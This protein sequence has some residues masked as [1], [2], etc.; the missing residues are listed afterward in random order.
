MKRKI[1][2]ITTKWPFPV[3][4]GSRVATCALIKV[5]VEAGECVDLL[6][7]AGE[8]EAVEASE[9]AREIG[10]RNCYVLRRPAAT[11]KPLHLIKRLLSAPFVPI[12]F[13][14]YRSRHM[15]ESYRRFFGGD[16][17]SCSERAEAESGALK[18]DVLVYDGPHAAAPSIVRSRYRR[19]A[20]DAALIYRAQNCESD[21][22]RGKAL[23]HRNP[24]TRLFLRFQADR[25]RKFEENLLEAVG[26]VAAV[27]SEDA[28]TFQ[29]MAPGVR[30]LVVPVGRRFQRV[31]EAFNPAE[32]L[33]LLFLGR[34]DWLPNRQGLE[35]LL[36]HVWPEVALRRPDIRLHIAGS[37]GS[38]WLLRFG[39][40]PN[41][42][43]IGRVAEVEALYAQTAMA[44]A[45]I[46][47]GSGTRVKAMEAAAC[48][49][50][51]IGTTLGVAGLGLVHGESCLK[52]DTKDEWVACLCRLDLERA[53]GLGDAA[54][55][56][57][58]ER[59]DPASAGNQFRR[60]MDWVCTD[61]AA[62]QV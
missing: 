48:G 55:C 6:A 22:W 33:P 13:S 61:T 14:R 62:I 58:R 25:V 20:G 38:G 7:L 26:G 16:V 2:W 31:P 3:E 17:S 11:Q 30:T 42:R 53:R 8:E 34:L 52:A 39:N 24:L 15:I 51:C 56:A 29:N 23:Q 4:D 44:V 19:L 40:L 9:A 59:F 35:W 54:F 21:I 27:S 5:L 60:L 41:L 50:A 36:N 46:F 32:G 57:L 10:I 12:T 18:W 1:L 45:P 49:R 43:I 37:G 28:E 47:Y